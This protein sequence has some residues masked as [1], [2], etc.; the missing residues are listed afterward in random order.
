[1]QELC[2][3]KDFADSV[4]CVCR[5]PTLQASEKVGTDEEKGL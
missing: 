3:V 2:S 1:M 5:D 4:N